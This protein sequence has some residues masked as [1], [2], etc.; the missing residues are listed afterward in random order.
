[1][2]SLSLNEKLVLIGVQLSGET[3]RKA[4]EW[5][6]IERTLYEA[7]LEVPKDSRLLSLLCSWVLVHGD[8]VIVEKLMRLQKDQS[9][10][11]LIAI[12]IFAGQ[13]GFHKWKRLI[14]AF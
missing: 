14:I 1:M 9:S 10:P 7:S 3:K 8:R 2:D 12:A 6:D 13:N 5:V 11:W 4:S